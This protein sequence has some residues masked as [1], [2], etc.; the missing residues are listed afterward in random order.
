MRLNLWA[1]LVCMLVPVMAAAQEPPAVAMVGD[2]ATAFGNNDRMLMTLEG[3]DHGGQG[4]IIGSLE[5]RTPV[6]VVSDEWGPMVVWRWVQVGTFI[7]PHLDAKTH[8][9]V[10]GINML[11][12]EGR[13]CFDHIY[14]EGEPYD[15][16][17]VGTVLG[18]SV[19]NSVL[20]TTTVDPD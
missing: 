11:E 6:V 2:P 14:H 12:M 17:F 10:F 5:L 15:F 19:P 9:Y 7:L 16:R 13:T 3:V 4:T 8:S 18:S 20:G 1:M